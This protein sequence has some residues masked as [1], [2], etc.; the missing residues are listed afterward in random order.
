VF[1]LYIFC[2]LGLHLLRIYI[3]CIYLSKN[4]AFL[5]VKVLHPFRLLRTILASLLDKL[6]YLRA[7]AHCTLQ[8]VKD[9]MSDVRIALTVK[10]ID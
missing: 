2:V 4:I 3:N 1:L 7:F 6:A 5:L 10:F 9:P 8:K